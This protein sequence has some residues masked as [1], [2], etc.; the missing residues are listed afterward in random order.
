MIQ[1]VQSIFIL[2]AIISSV[3]ALLFP[4][5]VI[6]VPTEPNATTIISYYHRII[7][8][9]N[10]VVEV[11]GNY[12][13]VSF[14]CLGIFLSVFALFGYKNRNAQ[15]RITRFTVLI[16]LCL[17]LFLLF[18]YN[19]DATEIN[20]KLGIYFPMLSLLLL[21]FASVFIRRDENLVRAA[22]RLR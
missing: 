2:V 11:K 22:D 6:Y 21:F 12:L 18:G 7:T 1:R 13:I 19:Q 17:I 14:L 9:I 16:Y 3:V 20:Y 8:D 10:G 15:Y 4:Y 5:S